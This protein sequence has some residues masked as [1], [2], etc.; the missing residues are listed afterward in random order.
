MKNS[1]NDYT[2]KIKLNEG[3][4]YNVI[5]SEEYIESDLIDIIEKHNYSYVIFNSFSNNLNTILVS[6]YIKN[7]K[8][9][10]KDEITNINTTGINK[11]IVKIFFTNELDNYDVLFI[12]SSGLSYASISYLAEYFYS[13]FKSLEQKTLFFMH[14]IKSDNLNEFIMNE[15]NSEAV[16]EIENLIRKNQKRESKKLEF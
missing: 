5:S 10:F 3:K 14:N 11:E 1:I 16:N 2:S 12:N 9:L 6:N 15:I 8:T 4:A 7:N 13:H